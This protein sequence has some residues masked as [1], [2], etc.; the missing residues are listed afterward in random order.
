ME[1]MGDD[2]TIQGQDGSLEE[3]EAP[4]RISDLTKLKPAFWLW[5]AAMVFYY[6]CSFPFVAVAGYTPSPTS[7][8]LF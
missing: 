3:E 6:S 1:E 5:V 2:L 7:L 4:F 8:S